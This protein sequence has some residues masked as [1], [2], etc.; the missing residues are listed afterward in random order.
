MSRLLLSASQVLSSTCKGTPT[1]IPDLYFFRDPEEAEKEYQGSTF[2]I[3][4]Q[5][6]TQHF[7]KQRL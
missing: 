7:H 1:D 6:V 3:S 4:A 5:R 2:S